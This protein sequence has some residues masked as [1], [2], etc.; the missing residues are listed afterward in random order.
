MLVQSNLSTLD[1][2]NAR[3]RTLSYEHERLAKQHA[4]VR[5][6]HTRLQTEL[7]G[8]KA[9]YTDLEKIQR[10]EEAKVKELREEVSRGR[11]AL[12][13]VRIAASVS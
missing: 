4:Q 1:A 13:G 6:A 7:A 8:W 11:K 12:E 3:H 2:L 9:R 5:N 10:E